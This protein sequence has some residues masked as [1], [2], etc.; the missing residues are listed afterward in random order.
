V[1]GMYPISAISCPQ[2][3]C[4]NP[5]GAG[6]WAKA[7]PGG[8]FL[9]AI[10]IIILCIAPILAIFSIAKR[11]EDEEM[12]EKAF[13]IRQDLREREIMREIRNSR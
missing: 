12:K 13:W 10:L 6:L 7:G 11:N 9:L 5:A 1:A 4:M 2:C 3:G 8:K